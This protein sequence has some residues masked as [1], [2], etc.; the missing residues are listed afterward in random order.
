MNN[1]SQD[2]YLFFV[3]GTLMSGFHNNRLLMGQQLLGEAVTKKKYLM[4]A[5][6]IPYV[7]EHI[8]ISKIKGELWSVNANAIAAIDALEGHPN[9]YIRKPIEVIHNGETKIAF[10]YFMQTNAKMDKITTDVFE[11]NKIIHDGDYKNYRS[12]IDQN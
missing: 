11:R 1:N 3:Y 12:T 5:S 2:N 10:I 9:W 7:Y 8:P 6:G 4:T